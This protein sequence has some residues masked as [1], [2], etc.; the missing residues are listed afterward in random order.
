MAIISRE[1]VQKMARISHIEVGEEELDSLV[2]SIESVLQYVS[3]LEDV[4]KAY[5]A[6]EGAQ[7]IRT[8]NVMRP[9]NVKPYDSAELLRK[10][11]QHEAGYFV[12]PVIIKQS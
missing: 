1:D 6:S 2:K 8:V 3:S 12:V 9:D 11:P 5:A 4:E 10:A 7:L